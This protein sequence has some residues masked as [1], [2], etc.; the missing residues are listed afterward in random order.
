M[1][2][3]TRFGAKN[4]KFYEI[5]AMSARTRGVEPVRSRGSIFRDFMRTSFMEVPLKSVRVY[6]TA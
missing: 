3:S 5:Y 2:T 4:F 1:R 6:A